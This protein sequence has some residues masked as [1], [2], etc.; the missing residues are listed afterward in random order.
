MRDAMDG[1]SAARENRGVRQPPPSLR[2]R[3]AGPSMTRDAKN[4]ETAACKN[5]ASARTLTA[6]FQFP[7]YAA[8][9]AACTGDQLAP[10]IGLTPPR[11]APERGDLSNA[12]PLSSCAARGPWTDLRLPARN[13]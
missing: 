4:T 10:R 6:A 5:A 2:L 13:H 12:T 9:V 7:P 8:K 1:A 3:N 11:P